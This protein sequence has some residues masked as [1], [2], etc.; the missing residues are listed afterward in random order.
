MDFGVKFFEK[1]HY[2][3]LIFFLDYDNAPH[4]FVGGYGVEQ[5]FSPIPVP[6]FVAAVDGRS[7]LYPM[8]KTCKASIKGC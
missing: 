4:Q 8:G 5:A 3:V 7:N 1:A 6:A 2:L